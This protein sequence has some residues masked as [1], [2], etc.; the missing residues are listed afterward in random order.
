ML[1][2]EY[3]VH[4]SFVSCFQCGSLVSCNHVSLMSPCHFSPITDRSTDSKFESKS[5]ARS[6]AI[7]NHKKRKRAREDKPPFYTLE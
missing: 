5:M 2:E 6:V 7:L 3:I 1:D 4:D